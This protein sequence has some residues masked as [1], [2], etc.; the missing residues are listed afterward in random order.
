[1]CLI[2]LSYVNNIKNNERPG[3][4]RPCHRV[5]WG[6][7]QKMF[8]AGCPEKGAVEDARG[9]GSAKMD[10]CYGYFIILLGDI[11]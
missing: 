9:L 3:P 2:S 11:R 4:G 5:H 7:N 1:M 10:P 6:E 8:T